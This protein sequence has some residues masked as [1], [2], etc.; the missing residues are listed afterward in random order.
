MDKQNTSSDAGPNFELDKKK[1]LEL[2]KDNELLEEFKN[3]NE[4]GFDILVLR[5]QEKVYQVA[6]RI[7]RNQEDAWELAQETFIRAYKAIPK[8][9]GKSSFYTWLFRICF[10]LSITFSKKKQKDRKMISLDTLPEET[11][12]LQAVN[13]KTDMSQPETQIK[14]NELSKAIS[15]AI[16]LLPVQQ[17][18][19]FV[20]RQYDDM[21][22]EEIASALNLSVSGVKS[23]YHHAVKK[24]KEI[25]KDWI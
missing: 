4:K 17:K 5:Y 25:L 12:T 11:I 9:K 1:P 22:N 24:L 23:N 10:N 6:F 14:Q 18:M 19:A 16:E 15:N 2:Y 21:K 20:M 7:V 13:P 3:G 8:F